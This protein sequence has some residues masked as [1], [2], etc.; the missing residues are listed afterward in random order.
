MLVEQKAGCLVKALLRR[1]VEQSLSDLKEVAKVVKLEREKV[2]EV[3][4]LRLVLQRSVFEG[5]LRRVSGE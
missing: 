1:V 4:G 5:S 3:R 2:D